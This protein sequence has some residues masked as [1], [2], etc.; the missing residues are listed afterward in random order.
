[1]PVFEGPAEGYLPGSSQGEERTVSGRAPPTKTGYAS[2]C[3]SSAPANTM[4]IAE[5]L[6]NF[7]HLNYRSDVKAMSLRALIGMMS[8]VQCLQSYHCS[9]N[10]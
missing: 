2:P 5:S 1:M 9:F 7:S 8:K 6:N 3:W 4:D 10:E